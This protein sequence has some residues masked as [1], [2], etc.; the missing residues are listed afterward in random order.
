M[1]AYLDT[2]YMTLIEIHWLC[3]FIKKYS[4]H[5]II[6]VVSKIRDEMG[7][8]MHGQLVNWKTLR[9]PSMKANVTKANT[10]R[11]KFPDVSFE[12]MLFK[13]FFFQKC[14]IRYSK[15]DIYLEKLW[16]NGSWNTNQE[17]LSIIPLWLLRQLTNNSSIS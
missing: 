3:D 8:V 2:I 14:R 16:E 4:K 13:R 1:R 17:I 9:S 10:M 15:W 11:K 6:F 12:F 5:L 7:A